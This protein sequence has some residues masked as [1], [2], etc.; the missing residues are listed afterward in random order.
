MIIGLYA[1]SLFKIYS[2][3]LCCVV[4]LFCFQ[5]DLVFFFYPCVQSVDLFDLYVSDHHPGLFIGLG[6]KTVFSLA[7]CAF[8]LSHGFIPSMNPAAWTSSGRI[9]SGRIDHGL[10]LALK[11]LSP[12]GGYSCHMAAGRAGDICISAMALIVQKM[13]RGEQVPFCPFLQ[14][15][16][17]RRCILDPFL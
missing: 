12:S 3:D 16:G 1:F 17:K 4:A 14:V 8:C 15:C 11:A 5:H 9:V 13:F 10:K 7:V 2:G 6:Y